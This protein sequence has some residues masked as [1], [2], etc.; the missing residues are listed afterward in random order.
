MSYL[1]PVI[2]LLFGAFFFYFI[3][4]EIQEIYFLKKILYSILNKNKIE[5]I[6]D[7]TKLKN[8]LQ[9]NISYNPDFREI[10]RPFLRHSASHILQSKYGFCGENARVSIKFFILGGAKAGRIYLFGKLWQHV[11]VEYNIAGD[12]FMFDGHFDP[13]TKLND[14]NV[15]K[16]KSENMKNSHNFPLL[17]RVKICNM[18]ED[19]ISGESEEIQLAIKL[20]QPFFVSAQTRDC[21]GTPLYTLSLIPVILN[22]KT[23]SDYYRIMISGNDK[24]SLDQAHKFISLAKTTFVSHLDENCLSKYEIFKNII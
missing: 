4:K 13:K 7:I 10:K 6:E 1:I 3:Y 21:D 18:N 11:L 19:W 9:T 20:R 16:I 17:S 5:S 15:G 8:Y 2:L 14:S 22:D 12:W 23:P 24:I